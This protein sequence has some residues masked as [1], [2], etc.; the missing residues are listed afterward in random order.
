MTEATPDR[1]TRHQLRHRPEVAARIARAPHAIPSD[2][3]DLM[4]E[5]LVMLG[6]RPM[7]QPD[8]K[9]GLHRG[10]SRE[11]GVADVLIHVIGKQIDQVDEALR[12]TEAIAGRHGE[13]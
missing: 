2:E 10:R 5:R 12:R 11:S 13:A 6:F 7:T 4:A 9:I 3:L 8:G 1:V